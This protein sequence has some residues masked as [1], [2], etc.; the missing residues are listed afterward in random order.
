MADRKKSPIWCFYSV[1]EDSRFAKCNTCKQ[2]ISRGGK[3][4]KTFTTSN[5]VSHL[6]YK[7]KAEYDEYEKK[8]EVDQNS[9]SAASAS[10]SNEPRQLTLSQSYDKSRLWD[11]NDHCAQKI[12]RKIGKMVALDCQPLSI[13]DDRGFKAV[14]NAL[15]PRYNLPSR[16]YITENVLSRIQ[17]GIMTQMRSQT[18]DVQWV[19]FTTDIWTTNVS[20]QSMISL[21]AHWLTRDFFRKSAVLNVK[22]FP[23]SHTGEN[24]CTILDEMFDS[25]KIEK[26]RVHLI[27]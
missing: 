1:A 23:E 2:E 11:I 10:S 3:T 18:S 8:K 17:T 12:H 19:S 20:N 6:K 22:Y 25:W 7:H 16:R 15:E 13:V 24:I 4:T 5:L 9:V 26:T 21:T 14:L 27:L